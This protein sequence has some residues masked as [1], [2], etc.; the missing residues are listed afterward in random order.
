MYVCMYGWMGSLLGLVWFGL[1]L[2]K[3][4]EKKRKG[5]EGLAGVDVSKL[6]YIYKYIK[7]RR[8]EKA[9]RTQTNNIYT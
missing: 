9:M 2:G 1:D 6:R 3:R 5:E 4:K 7:K 8:E